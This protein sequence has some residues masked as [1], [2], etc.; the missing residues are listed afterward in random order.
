M[1]TRPFSDIDDRLDI[2][3]FDYGPEVGQGSRS[4]YLQGQLHANESASM[5]VLHALRRKL[6]GEPSS[7]PIRI[8]PNSNPI[9]WSRYLETGEGRTSAD[10]MNWNRIFGHPGREPKTIDEVLAHRLW[11]LSQ[12]RDVIIDVHT[13]EF[14]WA[15]VYASCPA[16]R[17]RTFDD[18]PHVFYGPFSRPIR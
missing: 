1:T 14:G 9:G 10:G 5:I 18:I 7:I 13:P 3:F 8:V 15:H 12:D 17:L 11:R 4:V 16:T 2:P 6:E